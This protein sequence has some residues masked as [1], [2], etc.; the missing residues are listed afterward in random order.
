MVYQHHTA[1]CRDIGGDC[2]MS[3][4]WDTGFVLADRQTINKYEYI[5]ISNS[6]LLSFYI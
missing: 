4:C 1:E 5:S 6:D 3:E 2:Q